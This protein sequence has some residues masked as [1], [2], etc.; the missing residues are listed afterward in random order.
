MADARLQ[1]HH[2]AEIDMGGPMGKALAAKEAE[3]QANR[4]DV[5]ALL[6][7]I[8]QKAFMLKDTSM[9]D[10]CELGH[11][12]VVYALILLG[13][14]VTDVHLRTCAE[15][16]RRS[17]RH[18]RI[19][20][21]LLLHGA[22]PNSRGKDNHGMDCTARDVA[23]GG[24]HGT[25][26]SAKIVTLC[27]EST[28][29]KLS[30]DKSP[31]PAKLA[32]LCD[33]HAHH[34][35]G[36]DALLGFLCDCETIPD[37]ST[38]LETA[39]TKKVASVV[40]VLILAGCPSSVDDI[41]F[42]S[43]EESRLRNLPY[44]EWCDEVPLCQIKRQLQLE[45]LVAKGTEVQ[46]RQALKVQ[47]G[48]GSVQTEKKNAAIKAAG[49]E[50]RAAKAAVKEEKKVVAAE[51]ALSREKM[52]YSV[53]PEDWLDVRMLPPS[54]SALEV[55]EKDK[56]SAALFGTVRPGQCVAV[57]EIKDEFLQ[58]TCAIDGNK[59]IGGWIALP[60]LQPL[61]YY[62][63]LVKKGEKRHSWKKRWFHLKYPMLHYYEDEDEKKEKG[64]IN[65]HKC[66]EVRMSTHEK[67]NE[68]ELELI[69]DGREYRFRVEDHS[70]I[71]ENELKETLG[72]DHDNKDLCKQHGLDEWVSVLKLCIEEY[73]KT[74]GR[75]RKHAFLNIFSP[76]W[77]VTPPSNSL[78]MAHAT[79]VV[80]KP[81]MGDVDAL[82]EATQKQLTKLV[83]R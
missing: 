70:A 48:V 45:H 36:V 13:V 39:V 53:W 40:Q 20:R 51:L 61:E 4:G 67:A 80:W 59:C 63:W 24:G 17:D 74:P 42:V 65:L 22:N 28:A 9:N 57:T 8:Y 64:K 62:G 75:A 56:S 35:H 11:E 7:L 12:G 73:N 3:K 55:L 26:L 21:A 10:A 25:Q 18:A 50:R 46:L 14:P 76:G 15:H 52:L 60:P 34:E 5:E 69:A 47:W 31:L 66:T 72:A 49:D 29:G 2:H 1:D 77:E 54:F 27:D 38:Y 79:G 30:K 82:C 19:A 43:E 16:S 37:L 23:D 6:P 44:E 83:P 32:E 58:V 81:F 68:S 78:L 71:L 41:K 33:V